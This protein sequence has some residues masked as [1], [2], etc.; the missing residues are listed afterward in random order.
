MKLTGNSKVL[1]G[2]TL[3]ISG[4]LLDLLSASTF[5]ESNSGMLDIFIG[6]QLIVGGCFLIMGALEACAKKRNDASDGLVKKA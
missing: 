6:V 5:K 4:G 1:V 2:S 3:V